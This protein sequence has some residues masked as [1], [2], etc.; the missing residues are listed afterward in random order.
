M[1]EPFLKFI[2][3]I[4]LDRISDLELIART[5]VSGMSSG[6]HRSLHTGVSV[7]FAQYRP[8]VQGDDPKFVDWR[9]FGRTDRLH[10]K[11]FQEE[12][13]LRC[14]VLLDC[15]ASM[16][17]GSE[18]ITKFRYAQMLAASL[19]MLMS[20]QR[21]TVGFAAYHHDL[22]LHIPARA[23]A[24][25]VQR[26][27][28]EI[29][30]LVPAG[31]TDTA[32]ALQFMGDALSPRGMVVL[33]SDLLHPVEEMIAHLRSLRAQRHDLMVL[34]ISDPAERNFPFDRSVTLVDAEEGREQFTVPEAA[35]EAYLENRKQH[36]EAIRKACLAG[37]I[38][39]EEFMCTEPLD[40]ALH[41]LIHR[42]T[43]ALFTSSRRRGVG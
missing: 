14:T 5:V 30:N 39:V 7:E 27:L 29:D 18:G 12:T 10:I 20:G 11:Q 37:E 2:D 42:R 28:V 4:E 16:E 32:S 36:F 41:H 26:I 43:H 19:V 21:D 31:Q 13:N 17:Y 1:P 24:D 8:Y 15:S 3:P 35:R 9:L 40:R 22:C 33:I 34:Q 23:Q 25:Q 38:D 6:V